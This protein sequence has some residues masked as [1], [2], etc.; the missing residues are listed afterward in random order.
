[1][2]ILDPRLEPYFTTQGDDLGTHLFYHADQAKG[3]DV[4]F[5]DVQNFLRRTGFD[6]LVQ[7]FAAEVFGILDLA[8]QLAV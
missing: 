8:I 1:M 3:A 4:R 2:K 5:A 6:E 7:H